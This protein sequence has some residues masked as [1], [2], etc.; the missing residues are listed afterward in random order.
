MKAQRLKFIDRER[1]LYLIGW[2]YRLAMA[3]NKKG[4]YLFETFEDVF[5]Y[6]S[7][8]D[9]AQGEVSERQRE[10]EEMNRIKRLVRKANYGKGGN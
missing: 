3:T 1:E 5:D 7:L 10:A 2:G 4:E 9:E 8:L 6:K